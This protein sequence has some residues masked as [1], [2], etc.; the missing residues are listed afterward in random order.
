MK[1]YLVGGAVRDELLGTPVKDRDYVVVGKTAEYMLERGFKQVGKGFPVFLHP[2]TGE[3]YAL[4][5]K[6]RKTGVGHTA[7]DIISDPSV[8]LEDDLSRRD[9]TINAIA[10]DEETGEIVDPYGGVED[11]KNGVL[12]HVSE[13]F[14]EDP[15]RVLRV[16]RFA[17]RYADKGFTVHPDTIELM[18][19]IVASGE[20]ES[21]P[22]ERIWGEVSKSF[23]S[24]RPSVFF[25]V[26]RQCG[27]LKVIA[28]EIDALYGVPQPEAH[29][30]E[31]DSGIHTEMVLDRAVQLAP[32]NV[33]VAYAA[34]THDLGKGLT[35]R[36][37]WP[38]HI[39]HEKD[40]VKPV[41]EL[42]ER[43][44][45]P[46]AC[47]TLAMVVCEFHLHSHRAMEM[48]PGSLLTLMEKIGCLR[49]PER[50]EEFL[51]ACQADA[52]GRLGFENRPYPQADYLRKVCAAATSVKAASYIDAGKSGVEL[53]EAIRVGRLQAISKV[54]GV[55]RANEKKM[56]LC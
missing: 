32:G 37:Q 12:R 30:P 23:S 31:I 19:K 15:L 9:L 44:K 17:S 10:R 39:N 5:R 56:K 14:A 24:P 48:R 29:H 18:K 34:L 52:Q 2:L 26:L 50:I 4:A 54:R 6:E 25:S 45:V 3:E 11:L 20:I 28:P 21:L 33:A 46:T 41:K 16:A 1:N 43:W 55:E 53:G 7:F 51:A 22:Q 27:A 40:G 47:K 36:D 35:P 38:Q 13:A 42:S 8:T 49:R